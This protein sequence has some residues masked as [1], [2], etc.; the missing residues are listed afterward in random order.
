[1][2]SGSGH[3]VHAARGGV[4]QCCGA[5][6]AFPAGYHIGCIAGRPWLKLLKKLAALGPESNDDS[7]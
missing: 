6:G 5:V 7:L 2:R 4:R 3:G 1:M